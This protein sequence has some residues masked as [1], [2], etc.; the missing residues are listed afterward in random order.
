MK[1][2]VFCMFGGSWTH[3]FIQI[4]KFLSSKPE[5]YKKHNQNFD[6]NLD[7]FYLTVHRQGPIKSTL[8]QFLDTCDLVFD[9]L[10]PI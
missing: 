3:N 9:R 10:G 8:A 2:A 5:K 4:A 7:K 6:N 1:V